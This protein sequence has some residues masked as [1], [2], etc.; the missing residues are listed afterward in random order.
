MSINT[1]I[2]KLEETLKVLA[3]IDQ[4]L[5]LILARV[6]GSNDRAGLVSKDKSVVRGSGDAPDDL[7]SRFDRHLNLFMS[8]NESIVNTL[9]VIDQSFGIDT[10]SVDRP[11]SY[12]RQEGS[13][14]ANPARHQ[15]IRDPDRAVNARGDTAREREFEADLDGA[16]T[17]GLSAG[18][19]DR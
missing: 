16:I 5:A 8:L 14:P 19:G 10:G 15:T 2:G 6:G 7:S 4:R 11:K 18:H 13:L 3:D 12:R 9:E 1:N 17:Q